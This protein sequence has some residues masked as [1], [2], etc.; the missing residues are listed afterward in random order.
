MVL[1]HEENHDLSRSGNPKA[2]Q[3]RLMEITNWMDK[4]LQ[5]L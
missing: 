2:R 1:F 5:T 3:K 4:Y